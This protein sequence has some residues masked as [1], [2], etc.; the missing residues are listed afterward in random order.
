M[1]ASLN[2]FLS[3][4]ESVHKRTARL[5]PLIPKGKLEWRPAV[6]VFSLV[7]SFGTWQVLSAICLLNSQREDR[8]ATLVIWE[9]WQ[10]VWRQSR[11]TIQPSTMSL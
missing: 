6:D 3:R 10:R 11:A 9:T 5:L 8:T 1:Y 7:I 4:W 2:D